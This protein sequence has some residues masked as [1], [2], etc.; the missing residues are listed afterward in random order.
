MRDLSMRSPYLACRKIQ[1][2]LPA[3]ISGDVKGRLAEHIW[4]HVKECAKCASELKYYQ[5][6]DKLIHS[7]AFDISLTP[8][9]EEFWRQLDARLARKVGEQA[10][11]GIF[12]PKHINDI[13]DMFN[14]FDRV[15]SVMLESPLQVLVPA[16]AAFCVA[17]S[18][19][20]GLPFLR[21]ILKPLLLVLAG[22][23]RHGYLLG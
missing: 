2:M 11:D 6:L 21:E 13:R 8:S 3:Y 10:R 12:M 9:E 1:K 22:V 15:A 17:M 4:R 19:L 5:D 18:Q 16:A 20:S 14:E 23:L 7:T